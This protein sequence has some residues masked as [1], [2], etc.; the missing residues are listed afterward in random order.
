MSKPPGFLDRFKTK[1]RPAS[2]V[3]PLRPPRRTKPDGFKVQWVKL[4][5]HWI[6]TLQRATGLSTVQLA[7]IILRETF[8]QKRIDGEVV[9]S[10][11]VTEMNRKTRSRAIAELVKLGLIEVKQKNGEAVRVARLSHYDQ[12]D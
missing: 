5:A 8:K 7:H 10:T 12:E 11:K 4:P 9:L 1:P 3:V 6:E 2:N